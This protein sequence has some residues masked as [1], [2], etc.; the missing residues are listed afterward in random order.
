M[1][2][3]VQLLAGH[4]YVEE[5]RAIGRTMAEVVVNAAYLQNAEDEEIDRFRHFDTQSSY[6]H[7]KKLELRVTTQLSAEENKKIEAVA[8][9]ARSL[10]GRKD[11]DPSWS[12]RTLM[13]RAEH[14]DLITRL[15]LISL[16]VLTS[17][18]YGHSAIHGTFDALDPFISSINSNQL[19]TPA[20]RQEELSVSL[21]SVNFSL[22]VMCLFLNSMF[23]L[24]LD[25]A[26]TDAGQLN[27]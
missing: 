9:H 23:H 5:I 7:A 18:A 12:K 1:G 14:T 11:S 16:L 27:L 24:D 25:S 26:I 2:T 15:N 19:L 21:S 4:A 17:Y 22:S 8:D 20:N 6:K 13:Q 10:T 3:A